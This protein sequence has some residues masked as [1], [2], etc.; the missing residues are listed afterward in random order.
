MQHQEKETIVRR[1][2]FLGRRT[3]SLTEPILAGLH[4]LLLNY[5]NIRDR[6][7]KLYKTVDEYAYSEEASKKQFLL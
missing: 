4:A 7:D 3:A 5:S 1:S 2:L 6:L